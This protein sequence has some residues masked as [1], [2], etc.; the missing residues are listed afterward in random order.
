VVLIDG[1]TLATLM[2]DHNVGVA[3]VRS[4]DLKRIDSDFFSEE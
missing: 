3:P 2:I 4:F 1:P